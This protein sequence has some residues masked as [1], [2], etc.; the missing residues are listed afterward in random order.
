MS[1]KN[2]SKNENIADAMD[3][4]PHTINN[5]VPI[6]QVDPSSNNI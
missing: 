3:D 1:S 5:L 6:E 4:N 2:S